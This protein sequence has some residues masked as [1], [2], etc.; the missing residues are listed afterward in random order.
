MKN[1]KTLDPVRFG[2]VRYYV[3]PGNWTDP[4]ISVVKHFWDKPDTADL[5]ARA[6]NALRSYGAW[7]PLG[8]SF[9]IGMHSVPDWF[10]QV[11]ADP[12]CMVHS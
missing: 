9:A 8:G 3:S 4:D 7:N 6:I 1:L 2:D 11:L 12:K 10:N 5:R